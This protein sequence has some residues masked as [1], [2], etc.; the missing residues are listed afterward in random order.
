ME[1]ELNWKLQISMIKFQINSKSQT[2][3]PNGMGDDYLQACLA[4][5]A[6]SPAM[7]ICFLLSALKQPVCHL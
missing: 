2:K 5:F 6:T 3:T 4:K 7:L 1:P